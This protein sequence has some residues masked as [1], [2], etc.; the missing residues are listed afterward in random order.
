[1]RRHRS[2][3]LKF[4]L[5]NRMEDELSEIRVAGLFHKYFNF[6]EGNPGT[7]LLAWYVNIDKI[8]DGSISIRN[9]ELPDTKVLDGLDDEWKTL[10]IQFILHKRLTLTRL[11]RIYSRDD[12][13]ERGILNALLR[14]GIVQERNEGLF[15]INPYI[16]PH[17]IKVLKSEDLL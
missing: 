8:A 14:T 6:S 1:M 3:G 2:S 5:N 7:A 12:R 13:R 17:L 4:Y 15:I 9:P 11:E 10:L 16:E